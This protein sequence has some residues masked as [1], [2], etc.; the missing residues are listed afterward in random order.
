MLLSESKKRFLR[1]CIALNL[2]EG[3][4][5]KYDKT[6]NRFFVTCLDRNVQNVEE[7]TSDDI[8]EHLAR[9][10]KAVSPNTL[11]VYFDTLK[12]YFHY[13]Y[14]DKIIPENIIDV[15]EAPKMERK[16][17]P[18]FNRFEVETILNAFDKNTFLGFRNYTI[19][20]IFFA[21]GIRR[22]ELSKLYISSINFDVNIIKIVGKGRKHRDIP[23]SQTL[24]KVILKYL[25]RRTEYV[26][27]NKLFKSPYLIINKDGEKLSLSTISGIINK[28]GKDENI[29]G[30]RV[31]PHTFR[32][33]FAKFF[34]LNGG[35]LFSLQ[36]ML[37]HSDIEMTKRYVELNTVELKVQNDKFNP[38][39]NVSWKY[40]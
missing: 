14:R 39:D 19:A 27:E 8:R 17:I 12:S 20:C 6:L 9:L 35:D 30:V 31:S 40:Y 29:T 37:G 4:L 15:V 32:H 3:T 24:R 33:T 2:A 36:K 25:K 18:A 10:S 26:A 1:R 5:Q 34:L 16:E 23:L 13:L 21:T 7:I 11:K 28:I 22:E 38:F